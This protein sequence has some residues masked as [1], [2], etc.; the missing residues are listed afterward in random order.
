[1][2][3]YLMNRDVNPVN[4]AYGV[5]EWWKT[6]DGRLFEVDFN[7]HVCETMAY[8]L[9]MEHALTDDWKPLGIWHKDMTGGE[10][11]RE[12]GYEP[13]EDSNA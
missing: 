12:L 8:P 4:P 2:K 3:A 1:M 13:V 9:D 5:Y 11:M 7:V 10:A 6:E